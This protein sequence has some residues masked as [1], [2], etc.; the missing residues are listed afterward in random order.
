LASIQTCK[1]VHSNDMH[2]TIG[3][4]KWILLPVH[5][6]GVVHYTTRSLRVWTVTAAMHMLGFEVSV[7]TRAVNSY[8]EYDSVASNTH[9][10]DS[11]FANIV[12]V[13]GNYGETDQM[14]QFNHR[15][16]GYAGL[17]PKIIPVRGIPW[18][19]FRHLSGSSS[20]V[21]T[22]YLVDVWSYSFTEA[23]ASVHPERFN[24]FGFARMETT[25]KA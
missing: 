2:L 25:D 19:A 6:C 15:A 14:Q 4:L 23:K 8:A 7:S 9:L 3:A 16:A 20:K 24:T 10:V 21:N 22:Q 12:L 1:P 18:S 11:A 17:R 13:T 5:N